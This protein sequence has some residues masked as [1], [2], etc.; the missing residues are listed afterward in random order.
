MM[1][2]DFLCDI[3]WFLQFSTLILCLWKCICVPNNIYLILFM[4]GRCMVAVCCKDQTDC[5]LQNSR[6]SVELYHWYE[7]RRH[8]WGYFLIFPLQLSS[9]LLSA[10][11]AVSSF[12]LFTAILSYVRVPAIYAEPASIH[13]SRGECSGGTVPLHRSNGH[14]GVL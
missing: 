11:V 4:F 12:P 14:N 5:R 6:R 7:S 8:F 10:Q 9:C 2:K 1:V 13:A 3:S